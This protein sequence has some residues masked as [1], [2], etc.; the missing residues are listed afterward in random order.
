MHDA[1][2]SLHPT[3]PATVPLVGVDGCRGG[4]VAAHLPAGGD[5]G[6][7]RGRVAPDVATL[8][9][10]LPADA[11]V[12]IDV[13]IGLPDAGP[14]ACDAAAR[15]AL[16]A[17]RASVF[18]APVRSVLAAETYPDALA[19]HRAA[20]GRGLA[21]Q[22]YFLLPKIREVDA[23]LAATPALEGRVKETHPEL[24]FATL[25]GAPLAHGKRTPEGRSTRDAL[26]EAHLP[27]A[28]ARVRD[29]LAG[30]S[31]VAPDDVLD[32]V[33]LL[34]AVARRAAGRDRVLPARAADG[35]PR[36]AVGRAMEIH[37]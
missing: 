18:A 15:R 13:P 3:L 20:D 35:A 37:G 10:A 7:V 22:A 12:A 14:R 32:A 9:A 28:L 36:D 21:K 8:L 19:R 17:R 16:G 33:A 25:A 29:D 34:L 6:D 11:E 30:A 26:L 2:L 23:L 27:G 1:P 24:A 31:G 5:V 4:W